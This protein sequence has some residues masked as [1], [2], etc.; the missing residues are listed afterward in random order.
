MAS[1]TGTVH[2]NLGG[3]RKV[4]NDNVLLEENGVETGGREPSPS[5]VLGKKSKGAWGDNRR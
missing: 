5:S 2:E 1:G 3:W 4:L